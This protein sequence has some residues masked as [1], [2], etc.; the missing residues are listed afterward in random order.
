MASKWRGHFEAAKKAY[1]END[2]SG[3][4]K[5]IES[6][7]DEHEGFA[8][9][10]NMKGLIHYGLGRRS[11][12]AAAFEQAL[13]INPSYSEAS[14]NL[15]VVY[16]EL[17]K[18]DKAQSV[19]ELAKKATGLQVVAGRESYLDP[20][21]S[22][23]LANMHAELGAIYKDLG[24]FEKAV[25]EFKSA[26]EMKPGLIDVLTQLGVIYRDMKD[27][28]MSIKMLEEAVTNNSRFTGARLQLG[29]TYH[30]MGELPRAKAEW[31]KITREDPNN[32][33]ANMY[34]NF[35]KDKEAKS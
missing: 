31:L 22:G 21:V 9:V 33:M 10:H 4:L 14:L 29:L 20:Y 28:S 26:L 34:L 24:I 8:D 32:K 15:V 3:A 30:A 27:Y 18:V 2:F 12:A 11:E 19:Y 6:L 17:G 35:L 23:R 5:E 16:N 13:R 7:L 1:K 25:Y